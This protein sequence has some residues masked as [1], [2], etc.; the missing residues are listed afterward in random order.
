MQVRD[1]RVA[2][3]SHRS[4]LPPGSD[5]LALRNILAGMDAGTILLEDLTTGGRCELVC[6][7]TQRQKEMLKAG[8][9]LAYTA[10]L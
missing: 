4:D 9:L 6:D 3:Q 10:I 8:G 5:R 2:G 1:Q 7:F